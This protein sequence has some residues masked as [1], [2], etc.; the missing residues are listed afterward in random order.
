MNSRQR[1][2]M[3]RS[4]HPV[5]Y[6]FNKIYF[7]YAPNVNNNLLEN[8]LFKPRYRFQ[9]LNVCAAVT[10]LNRPAHKKAALP[11]KINQRI[12]FVR[13]LAGIDGFCG[14]LDTCPEIAVKTGG[15]ECRRCI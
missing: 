1:I 2:T 7:I 13:G 12:Q 11:G 4:L 10:I 9:I 15:Y 6:N 14:P 8:R 5:I 3:L